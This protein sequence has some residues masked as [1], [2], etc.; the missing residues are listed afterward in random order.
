MQEIEHP[1]RQWR[2]ES[3][4]A[5]DNV[6][7]PS[8]FHGLLPELPRAERSVK[9]FHEIRTNLERRQVKALRDAALPRRV[10]E[11]RTGRSCQSL[12]AVERSGGSHSW[13]KPGR[14]RNES[15]LPGV[16]FC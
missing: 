10:E 13:I 16:G 2:I 7:P 1:T 9:L 4:Q 11:W 6:E 14:P 8:H 12:R 5:M 15:Q 3:V